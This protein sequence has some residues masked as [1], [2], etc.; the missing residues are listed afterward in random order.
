MCIVL[1]YSGSSSSGIYLEGGVGVGKGDRGHR[2][3]ADATQR[4]CLRQQTCLCTAGICR[5]TPLSTGILLWLL[6]YR[7]VPATTS[8]SQ[9]LPGHMT[10]CGQQ[11]HLG[12]HHLTA[13]IVVKD[14]NI[15]D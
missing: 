2:G 12:T 7:K 10:G 11:Q 4:L 3:A 14:R 15:Y 9:K 8:S 6:R 1:L 13:V 5:R